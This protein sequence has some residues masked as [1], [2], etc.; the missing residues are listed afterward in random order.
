MIELENRSADAG[1]IADLIKTK[2]AA[3][4][5][6]A[7]EEGYVGTIKANL[8]RIYELNARRE[9]GDKAAAALF[10]GQDLAGIRNGD[11]TVPLYESLFGAETSILAYLENPGFLDVCR[12]VF[13]GGKHENTGRNTLMTVHPPAET[14]DNATVGIRLHT[15]GMYYD[16]ERFGLTVWIPLDP[17]G[18]AAPG[19]ELVIADH[20]DVRAYSG[21]DLRRPAPAERKWNWHKYR[22]GAFETD[23]IRAHYGARVVVP[24][25]RPG[26]VLIFS[27]W[28]IHG[29]HRTPEMTGR[30]SAIHLRVEGAAFD[31]RPVGWAPNRPAAW[32]RALTGGR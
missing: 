25:F 15:D 26:D 22:P 11:V 7:L 1:A 21:F 4:L 20:H 8:A 18:R 28:T 30:R 16:D 23:V 19:L 14:A 2:G 12:R 27:N 31:P 24:E 9:A 6:N 3:L 13:K 32:L 17:C 29:T 10:Q 5:R